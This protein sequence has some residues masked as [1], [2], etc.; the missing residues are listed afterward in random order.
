LNDITEIVGRSVSP[1]TQVESAATLRSAYSFARRNGVCFHLAYLPSEM[2]EG[3]SMGFDTDYTRRLYGYG[4][5]QEANELT[6]LYVAHSRS[7]EESMRWF[8]PDTVPPAIERRHVR[9]RL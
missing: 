6:A 2:P 8:S 4:Y 7:M 5:R 3:G 9:N 1:M